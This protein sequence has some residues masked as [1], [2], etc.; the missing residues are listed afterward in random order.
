MVE[1]YYSLLPQKENPSNN[2]GCVKVNKNEK[3]KSV[4]ISTICS[5]EAKKEKTFIITIIIVKK[6]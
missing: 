3:K 5:N 4:F 2:Y 1:H 6:L